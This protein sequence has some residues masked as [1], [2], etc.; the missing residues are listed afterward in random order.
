M[1]EEVSA[2]VVELL[3]KSESFVVEQAP[4][5]VQD[6]IFYSYFQCIAITFLVA[7]FTLASFVTSNL[8]SK[9]VYKNFPDSIDHILTRWLGYFVTFLLFLGLMA[10]LFDLFKLHFCQKLYI[11]EHFAQY[12]GG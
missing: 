9:Q 8:I 1:N 3:T 2:K 5:V 7:L 4:Q 6:F 11:F 12:V 10:S